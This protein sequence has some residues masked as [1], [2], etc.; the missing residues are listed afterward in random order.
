MSTPT[1]YGNVGVEDHSALDG[2]EDVE[3]NELHPKGDGHM[4]V[5]TPYSPRLTSIHSADLPH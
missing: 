2:N 4:E 5:N 3:M 1:E